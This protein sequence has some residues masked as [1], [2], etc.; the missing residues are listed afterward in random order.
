MFMTQ[1]HK[2]MW[3]TD[4]SD[5]I[6]CVV[7]V[8]LFPDSIPC[9]VSGALPAAYPDRSPFCPFPT[10]QLYASLRIRAAKFAPGASFSVR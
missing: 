1:I 10:C 3:F 2:I 6:F 8:S 4:Y 7:S 5:T 9:P